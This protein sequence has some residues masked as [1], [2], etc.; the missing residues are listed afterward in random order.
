MSEQAPQLPYQLFISYS[1]ADRGW[2]E[3]YLL[4]ALQT[5]NVRFHS[6]LNFTLGAPR[7]TE[8]ERAIKQSERTLLVL[9]PAYLAESI[10][11]FV[12]LMAQ[13]W[14][15]ES[16]TWPVIP[17]VLAPVELPPRLAMLVAL[18][19]TDVESWP[20]VVARLCQFIHS[21]PP[22]PVAKPPCP[23]PGMRAFR[24]EDATHFYGREAEVDDLVQRL[25]VHPFVAVIGASGSGK[26][27]LVFAGLIPALKR[28][29]LFGA[30]SWLVRAMRPGAQP[31]AAMQ[32]ALGGATIDQFTPATLLTTEQDATHLLLV[33]DQFEEVFTQGANQAAAFF[34]AVQRFVALRDCYVVITVR[35]DF[36][37]T[38]LTSTLWP[39]IQAHRLEIAYLTASGLRSAIVKPAEDVGVFIESALVERLVAGSLGQ[40]G[41][42]PFVQEVLVRLWEKL[43]RRYLPLR[44]YEALVLPLTGYSGSERDNIIGAIAQLANEIIHRLSPEQQKI[45]RRI[46]L[47]LV[48]F[49]EGRDHTR[50]QQTVSALRA[51]GDDTAVVD[52]TLNYLAENR[53]LVLSGEEGDE[54]RVDLAHE[55]MLTGWPLLKEWVSG[56]EA[57]E[58]VRRRLE[59]KAAEWIRLD[60]KG[61]LLDESEL[62][63]AQDWLNKIDV[64]DIGV[65]DRL[66]EFVAKSKSAVNPGWNSLGAVL[67]TATMLA[68]GAWVGLAYVYSIELTPS[69]KYLAW[70]LIFLSIAV[71]VTVIMAVIRKDRYQ[72]QRISQSLAAN[73]GYTLVVT[74][75]TLV[76]AIL[77]SKWGMN[78][79]E[80]EQFCTGSEHSFASRTAGWSNIA[81]VNESQFDPYYLL[82]IDQVLSKHDDTHVWIA[83]AEDVRACRTYFDYTIALSKRAP[84][85]SEAIY[86]ATPLGGTEIIAQEVAV[87]ESCQMAAK[88]GYKL[89]NALH[90]EFPGVVYDTNLFDGSCRAWILNEQGYD[91]VRSDSTSSYDIKMLDEAAVLFRESIKAS[92]DTYWVA[93]NNLG[94]VLLDKGA[95]EELAQGD[96]KL[97]E[98][99]KAAFERAASLLRDH[100]PYLN[101]VGVACLAIRDYD[102]AEQALRAAVDADPTYILARSNLGRAYLDT[103]RYTQAAVV[104][105]EAVE[106]LETSTSDPDTLARDR[107]SVLRTLGILA[108]RQGD[109]TTA[110]E[111]LETALQASNLYREEILYYLTLVSLETKPSAEFCSVLDSYLNAATSRLYGERDRRFSANDRYVT[112]KCE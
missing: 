28:S 62:A 97:F 39:T 20:D 76:G 43:E 106:L 85:S 104:L 109:F 71:T 52:Y 7:V 21:G 35:S 66:E 111:H 56:Y 69:L 100:A 46:F 15:L 40:P 51:A 26:S 78:R 32:A 37:S 49:G 95:I 55:A 101:D 36:F 47:R 42:L 73:R 33:I 81:L 8:F 92:N 79:V 90:L 29:G 61:G 72:L 44:A 31:V 22:T 87:A 112:L 12:D 103:G 64:A 19:A 34:A 99:A 3:G 102:C 27:S 91:V 80:L 9:S 63:E 93:F 6:E 54:P 94:H 48:Q 89:A 53:L 67:L 105:I 4:D 58:V 83:S 14:G 107:S 17:L 50:R 84:T 74:G 110:E 24:Q 11:T 59:E 108:Y 10:T 86:V 68:V 38:L 88:F 13:I 82:V 98:E 60:K 30:G 70:L 77:W 25:R 41:L 65:S 1:Q 5:A 57:D 75:M 16:G 2:V 18:D 45:A 23:Y 96:T